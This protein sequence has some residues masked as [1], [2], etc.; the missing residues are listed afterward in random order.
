MAVQFEFDFD[1]ALAALA[2]LASRDVPA[3]DVY[4]LHKLLFLADKYHLVRYGRPITGDQYVA[5]EY[6]PVPSRTYDLLKAYVEGDRDEAVTRL[7][8]FLELEQ[9]YK[10]PRFKAK[11]AYDAA[12][13]SQS[14]VSALERT[15]ELF[16]DK[17]FE[18]LKAITHEMPAFRRAW[19]ARP[20]DK[21]SVPMEFEAFFEEDSE[22]I[23][24]AFEEMLENDSLRK[25]FPAN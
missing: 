15:V 17:T 23:G 11:A 20:A 7:A 16:G 18:E 6:G 9:Q 13:F 21:K 8:G 24:G 22:A 3:L 12:L 4:K 10:Y 2:Y 5:M 14:D 1:K 25:A 19:E